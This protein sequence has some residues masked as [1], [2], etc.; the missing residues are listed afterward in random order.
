MLIMAC[1]PVILTLLRVPVTCH[2]PVTAMRSTI[3]DAIVINAEPRTRIG[4]GLGH[5]R[6][7]GLT[8]LTLYGKTVAPRSLQADTRDLEQVVQASGMSQLVEVHISDVHT[9]V[10]VL[11]REVQRHPVQRHL[12]HVDVYALQMDEKQTLQIPLHLTGRLSSEIPAEYIVIQNLDHIMVETFPNRIPDVVEV[13]LSL[14]TLDH[15]I[16]ISDLTGLEGVDFLQET[17]EVIVSLSRTGTEIDEDEDETLGEEV[18]PQSEDG[19]EA[20]TE[21]GG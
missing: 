21:A 2:E 15:N 16:Q 4:R 18:M 5:L 6:R 7:Q 1:L 20:S 9:V 8:P 14:L 11:L 13:D 10:Q 17:D 19:P 3:V 12:L